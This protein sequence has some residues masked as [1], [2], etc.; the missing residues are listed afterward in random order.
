MQN[1]VAMRREE[2]AKEVISPHHQQWRTIISINKRQQVEESD[3]DRETVRVK[4]RSEASVRSIMLAAPASPSVSATRSSES[5]ENCAPHHVLKINIP[6]ASARP[7]TMSQKPFVG[8]LSDDQKLVLS[9]GDSASEKSDIKIISGHMKGSMFDGKCSPSYDDHSDSGTCSDAEVIMQPPPV[10]PKGMRALRQQQQMLSDS[11]SSASSSDS[12][13]SGAIITLGG[14][15]LVSPDLIRSIDKATKLP[16]SLLLDIRSHSVSFL[17][18]DR[19]EERDKSSSSDEHDEHDEQE[20]SFDDSELGN[21]DSVCYSDDSFYKFHI[22]EHLGYELDACKMTHDESD[23]SFAGLRDLQSGTST[24]RSA[25]GTIRG[26]KN[27]VRNGIA[28]F[29]QMQQTT[30]KVSPSGLV[31]ETS[32]EPSCAQSTHIQL[33]FFGP[34]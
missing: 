13:Q 30:V 12:V 14:G 8:N 16:T 11:F 25:K 20:S 15:H 28:T 18:R 27:R 6:P 31:G 22:N 17:E 23:E 10:P 4:H 33:R 24:I 32:Y 1:S 7:A 9:V 19:E 21:R 34:N 3:D 2:E 29:L 26:V 5:D